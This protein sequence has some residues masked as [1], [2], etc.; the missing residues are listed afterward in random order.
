MEG[1][2][3][4]I[5]DMIRAS[6]NPTIW[7]SKVNYMGMK[8][9]QTGTLTGTA[10]HGVFLVEN[11]EV[12]K[13][14][15]NLRFEMQIPEALRHVTHLGEPELIGGVLGGEDPYVIPPMRIEGFRFIGA[16]GRTK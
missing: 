14:V 13:P 12:V 7:I 15:E 3:A 4:T 11:G 5:E 8:H 10:Q 2:D 1:G 16:T 6:K 9:F